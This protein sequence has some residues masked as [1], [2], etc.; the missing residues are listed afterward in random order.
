MTALYWELYAITNIEFFSVI[1]I[2]NSLKTGQCNFYHALFL[3]LQCQ[4]QHLFQP[5][6]RT[7][8]KFHPTTKDITYL[9]TPRDVFTP[10]PS[11]LKRVDLPT[12]HLLDPL[13]TWHFHSL[14]FNCQKN[15]FFPEIV[16]FLKNISKLDNYLAHFSFLF[17]V[18]VMFNLYYIRYRRVPLF[19]LWRQCHLSEY[20]WFLHLHVHCWIYR[21]RIILHGWDFNEN[22]LTTWLCVEFLKHHF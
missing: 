13:P 22:G 17:F 6:V 10:R 20:H 7:R 19:T 1:L 16:V 8:I 5:Q 12:P 4:R 3:N 18:I 15:T 11:D 2:V 9:C 21:R 14:Y